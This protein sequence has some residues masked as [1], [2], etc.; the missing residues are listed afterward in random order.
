[1]KVFII[2]HFTTHYTTMGV[3]GAL[4]AVHHPAATRGWFV[5]SPRTIRPWTHHICFQPG[6][7]GDGVVDGY[8]PEAQP[9]LNGNRVKFPTND[10]Q[11]NQTIC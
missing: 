8:Y 9:L 10:V 3:V 2:V 1:M 6:V 11:Q 4:A 5:R 7:A